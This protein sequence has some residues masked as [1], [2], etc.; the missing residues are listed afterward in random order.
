MGLSIADTRSPM[1]QW[2]IDDSSAMT[3]EQSEEPVRW[4]R[5]TG[6]RL[7]EL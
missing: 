1:E 4:W 3:E 5:Q 7:E 6:R 2:G